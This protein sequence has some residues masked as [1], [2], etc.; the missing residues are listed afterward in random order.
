[1]YP[2]MSPVEKSNPCH[3]HAWRMLLIG[4]VFLGLAGTLPAQTTYTLTAVSDSNYQ[5]SG[6]GFFNASNPTITLTE[7]QT[8]V[9]HN[10]ANGH[11]L[12]LGTTG[13]GTNYSGPEVAYSGPQVGGAASFNG[14][15]TIT[16]N[17]STPRSLVYYCILHPSMLGSIIVQAPAVPA[18]VITESPSSLEVTAG[19]TLV[20]AVTATSNVTPT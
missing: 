16:P 11:P 8:Y 7:G 12:R 4:S 18:P 9:F 15:I 5:V 19:Q 6:G 3:G 13:F 1:M 2:S 14:Q 17:A 10:Q 20:L